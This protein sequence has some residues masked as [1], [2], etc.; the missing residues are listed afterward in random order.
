MRTVDLFANIG[1]A[2]LIQSLGLQ[3][4]YTETAS[5]SINV[6]DHDNN[7]CHNCK[8]CDII[9]SFNTNSDAY[10]AAQVICESCPHKVLTTK[11]V[12]KKI[13]HNEKNRYGYKPRLKSNSIK[14]LLLLHFYHPDKFG[15]ICNA[16]S[17]QLAKELGC[18]IKTIFNNLEILS[19]YNYI[20]YCKSSTYNIT[21]CLN[22]YE[23]YYLPANKGGRG[24]FVMSLD[25]L[26]QII[27]LENLLTLR[28]HLR[29][30][31]E[32]D[33]LNIK[34]PFTAVSKTFK[35]IKLVLPDYCRPCI[36]KDAISKKSDIF[37]ISVNDKVIRFEINDNFNCRRRKDECF[38]QYISLFKDFIADFNQTVISV[39]SS[40]VFPDDSFDFFSAQNEKQDIHFQF[41]KIKDYEYDD[42]AQLAMQ[43]SY[44]YVITA[45][46][47]VYN[48][49]ILHERE[50][51]NL[52]GLLRTIII[53]MINN[54]TGPGSSSSTGSDNFSA[55]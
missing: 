11:T 43:Y 29:E 50:I 13:Y 44:N 20:S 49:Y 36:I 18:D 51:T 45:L 3:K 19:R 7:T 53:S 12:Y 27:Q 23:S 42:L 40:N 17:L 32:I 41:I 46:S 24:F 52:G 2:V 25:L 31:I 10:K 22:D 5:E 8:Y 6:I 9:N 34:A 33:N 48:N 16:N 37:D 54:S 28:I 47:T 14:L 39:N 15:V 26:K 55:A 35:E 21:V 4:N 38:N 30:L 1:K